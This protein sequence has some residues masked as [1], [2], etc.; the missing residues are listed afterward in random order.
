MKTF[1]KI[2][3]FVL[4]VSFLVGCAAPAAPAATEAPAVDAP[5]ATEVPATDAPLSAQEQWL[6]DNQ[7]GQFDTGEQDW[8]AIEAAAGR[9]Q[10]HHPACH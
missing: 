5:A 1:I 6:M 8:D 4:L 3:T 2:L 10:C 7:L 9:R